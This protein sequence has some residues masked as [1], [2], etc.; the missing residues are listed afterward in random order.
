MRLEAENLGGMSRR[1][2]SIAEQLLNPSRTSRSHRTRADNP[3]GVARPVQKKKI[4]LMIGEYYEELSR[5]TAANAAARAAAAKSS[6]NADPDLPAPTIEDNNEQLPSLDGFDEPDVNQHRQQQP[7]RPQPQAGSRRGTVEEANAR[8]HANWQRS[9]FNF[10]LYGFAYFGRGAAGSAARLQAYLE[11]EFDARVR[12]RLP[13]LCPQ[14]LTADWAERE[15]PPTA[16]STQ[17]ASGETVRFVTVQGSIEAPYPCFRCRHCPAQLPF[18]RQIHPLEIGCFPSTPDRPVAWFDWGLMQQ[19][20]FL[21]AESP[22]SASAYSKMLQRQHAVNGLPTP[23]GIADAIGTAAAHWDRVQSLMRTCELLGVDDILALEPCNATR[24]AS[25]SDAAAGA[26]AAAGGG[27]WMDCPA[28]WRQCVAVSGDAC[29]GL[30]RFKAAASGSLDLQPLAAGDLFISEKLVMERLKQR[31]KMADPDAVSC[32]EFKAAKVFGRRAAN[33]DRLG[34]AAFACRHGF[35]PAM[36]SLHTEE[37]FVYYEVLL[38]AL[39]Q[40]MDLASV[41]AVFL[42]VA[43]KFEG[44]YKRIYE[45]LD[46]PAGLPFAIGPWH[47]RPHKPECNVRYN[48]RYMPG[49]GL[50]FG[51]LIEHLWA[52]IRRHWYITAYM[53]PAARQDF[54]NGLVRD[55]HRKKEEGLARQLLAGLQHALKLKKEIEDRYVGLQAWA[56][57][58][59]PNLA[60]L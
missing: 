31:G 60:W 5:S 13:E 47:I 27:R 19:V 29:L 11:A 59:G 45:E 25:T 8:R 10:G 12:D 56:W 6:G 51:D 28:C 23:A 7:P 14:C 54:I 53:S 22:C 4:R 40:R 32:S 24:G 41:K 37:N 58:G 16:P 50:T 46:L 26:V 2:R 43:C 55:R 57:Y 44:Y 21:R 20:C 1:Y 52:D 35:V 9:Y 48:S 38:E 17:T 39:K 34:V 49:L 3:L 30:R 36:V 18:V 15:G 33:Y 42:D